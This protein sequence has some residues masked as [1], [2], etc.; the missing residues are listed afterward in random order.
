MRILGLPI[1][2]TGERR[3]ALNT[4]SGTDRGGWWPV[5]REP[6]T[7]AWQRN[8]TIDN[9]SIE[10]FHANFTCKT[11][12]ASDFA[13]LR[14]KYVE[15]DKD[16]IW[17]EATNPAYS[18]VLRRPNHYQNR[19][20]FLENWM[21]SKLSR[22]N[23]Y[24]LK[25]RDNRNVVIALYVLDPN[26]CRPVV[27]D[28]GAVFYELDADELSGV[29]G[30]IIVPAREI[31]HDRFN[32]LFHPLVGVPPVFASG[33][34]AQQGVNIQLNSIRLFENNS[35]P[36]GIL[37]APGVISEPTAQRLK[38]DWEANYSGK[39]VGRVAVLGDGLKFE[40]MAM[41]AVEGQ[42][43][44]QLKW[45][46]EVVCSTYHVPPYKIGVGALPSY[47]NI[48]A[49]N[50][51]YYSQCLQVLIEAAELCL[52][53]GLEMK[54]GAGTEFDLDNLLRMDSVTQFDVLEKAKSVMTLDERRRRL[55]L[56][57]ITG[58]ATVYL[59]Q[60]DHSIEA[61]A[62]RDKMLI[63]ESKRPVAKLAPETPD[64]GG[65]DEVDPVDFEQ[66][67]AKALEDDE[68]NLPLLA[69]RLIALAKAPSSY[70]HAI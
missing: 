43:I 58:G 55:D 44:E 11:L 65:D 16:G 7:G 66:D 49:L 60:Q 37:T 6:F 17:S 61:I 3:K 12:I 68:D 53:E 33:Y 34:A 22:G 69:G 56:K 21:L 26:R 64:D 24:V 27:S 25:Q 9:R 54:V 45:T 8:V 1:P 39:N 31:I 14:I 46:A 57:G 51:E 47:N 50:V 62:A 4:V 28:D 15:Q 5:I 19:I 23:T 67:L 42:L 52:D 63:E 20:Q 30:R 59:Q 70:S 32:C 2:F 48:Q 18:P 36:G 10:A 29:E 13:K 35:S 40:K 41:T 38:S